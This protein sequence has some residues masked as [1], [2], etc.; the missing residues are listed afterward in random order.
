MQ[1]SPGGPTPPNEWPH[2]GS[3]AIRDLHVRYA[4]DLPPVLHGINLEIAVRPFRLA[5]NEEELNLQAGER[6]GLVGATGSGKSTLALS[7]FRGNQQIAGSIKIDGLGTSSS[8]T[9]IATRADRAQIS[10]LLPSKPCAA[11]STWSSKRARSA[12]GRCATRSTSAASEVS[13]SRWPGHL[14]GRQAG[15]RADGQTTTRCTRPSAGCT[16]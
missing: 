16:C 7:I 1:A 8:E 10:G 6:V 5:S 13:S 15:P 9:I 14:F 4:E 3:I 12:R 11:A 2:R